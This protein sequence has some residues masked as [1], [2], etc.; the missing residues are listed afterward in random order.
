[1]TNK[2]QKNP[3]DE[4][5]ADALV[6]N[7]QTPP[8]RG[9]DPAKPSSINRERRERVPQ[10]NPAT[11]PKTQSGKSRSS[12][13]AVTHGLRAKKIENAVPPALRQQYETL[14]R[15][16]QSEYKP[17]GAIESTL[18]DMLIF[19]AWQLYKV[20]EME[21]YADIDLGVMGSFGTSE[22]LSRYRASHERLMFRSLN[23]LRQI[24][25]ERLLRETDQ[26]A[27]LPPQN[28]PRVRRTPPFTHLK[29]L[30]RHPK[31]KT[32]A[33]SRIP[34]S[35][36]AKSGPKPQVREQSERISSLTLRPRLIQS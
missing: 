16:Y 21:L 27:A 29:S 9:A 3:A 19:A 22:K 23:Q 31:T 24:Q 15:D 10:P 35:A 7:G 25:Q 28:P 14:R 33:T 30:Q 20:R 18:L 12:K 13:N 32:A 5:G 34:A 4:R 26:K 6:R 11:G 2:N 17:V 8:P 1:M 36:N